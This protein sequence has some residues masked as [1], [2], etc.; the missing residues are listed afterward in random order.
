VPEIFDSD[1]TLILYEVC[2]YS[3]SLN[4]NLNNTW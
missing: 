2:Q 3:S 1:K 4:C